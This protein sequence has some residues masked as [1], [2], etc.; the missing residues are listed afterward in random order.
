MLLSFPA[1]AADPPQV[2]LSAQVDP[3][4]Q[5]ISGEIILTAPSSV[6]LVDVLAQLPLPTDD[7]SAYRTWPAGPESGWL[8]IDPHSTPGR[9]SFYAILPR[10]YDASGFVPGRGLF[11]NGLW[12]PQ[13]VEGGDLAV[14]EWEVEVRL[15]EGTVGALNDSAGAGVLR[16]SGAAE[17]LSLAVIPGG[18]LRELPLEAGRLQVLDDRPRRPDLDA[19]L[20][21]TLE[22]IWPGPGA[23]E[24]VV[25]VTPSRRRLT[26]PGPG[27]LFLS[28]RAF[29]VSGGLWRY[30]V[31]AVRLGLLTAGLPR[32]RRPRW[33]GRSAG[34]PG[35][36]RWTR[37]CTTASFRSSPMSSARSGPAIRWPTTC[38]R[39]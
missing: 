11:V 34:S 39:S 10:R 12:H 36:P 21:E 2:Y 29:R 4:L 25:V 31:Q 18:Y 8:E 1:W 22:G 35:C 3:S 9:Y 38:R 37:C 23:P 15:P 24:L 13:P 17:R 27:V 16:W 14:V 19:H 28:D 30:H 33:S 6:R 26:R 32:P 7:L 5:V 20:A